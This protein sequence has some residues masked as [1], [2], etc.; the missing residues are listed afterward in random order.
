[1]WSTERTIGGVDAARDE[2]LPY[3]G[4]A[5]ALPVF[6]ALARLPYA[7][8]VRVW[9]SLLAAAFFALVL[10]SLALAGARGGTVVMGAALLA[11]ASGPITSAIA[12]GQV[13]LLSAGGIAC[14]LVA[15]ERRALAAGAVATLLAG[16]QP[17]LA[18][19][20]IARMRDR[21]ALLS[22]LGGA[23]AFGVL[24]LAAGGGVAGFVA[25]VHRLGE[26]ASAERFVA[27]QHTPGAIAWAF[28]AP[29]AL[30]AAVAAA[31]AVIA[32][33]ATVVATVR[34]RLD[35][36]DGA[37][38]ALA[39]APL[40]VPFFHE[41][42]FVVVLIVLIVLAVRAQGAARAWTGVAAALVCVDWFGIAQRPAA[43][44]Q[45]LATGIA[46][47]CAFVVLG[48][49]ARATRADLAPFAAIVVLACAA[50]PLA[51]AFPAPVWPDALPRSYH[52]PATAEASAVWAGEQRAAGLA[53]RQPAWG[54]LRA[55]PLA[56]CVV[57]GFTLVRTRRRTGGSAEG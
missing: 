7:V 26:H 9:T 53:V 5:A 40:A 54:A 42:D 11:A 6:G 41:H 32:I 23:F 36:R 4:P 44:A 15:Y 51:R 52:A 17:N 48:K 25:Y 50:V 22:A 33:A 13:A 27:I 29:D 28:G 10:A 19:A 21:A 38:L 2:L 39:A 46:V 45:I 30:A 1:M 8:A 3:V 14:A 20:L 55:L 43:A 12:L 16:L 31:V 49:G 57:L 18:L 34:A 37:L 35:A 24:T 56:G 47:A